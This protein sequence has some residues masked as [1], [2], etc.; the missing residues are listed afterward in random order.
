MVI[1]PGARISPI[2]NCRMTV[3]MFCSWFKRAKLFPISFRESQVLEVPAHRKSG[4]ASQIDIDD[5]LRKL[6]DRGIQSC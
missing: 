2:A 4:S 1:D 3:E 5:L 6:G